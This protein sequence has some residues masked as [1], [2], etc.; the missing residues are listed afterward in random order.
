MLRFVICFELK[1]SVFFFVVVV[2]FLIGK[3]KDYFEIIVV[4][5]SL[6]WFLCELNIVELCFMWEMC[7]LL[8]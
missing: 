7:D 3:S 5:F 6:V 1:K 2:V 8:I 4:K